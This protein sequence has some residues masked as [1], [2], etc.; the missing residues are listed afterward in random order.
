MQDLRPE[1]PSLS[2]RSIK[3]SAVPLIKDKNFQV[4][5]LFIYNE[6]DFSEGE[7]FEEMVNYNCI[8]KDFSKEG[9]KE[10]ML[11][12]VYFKG[13]LAIKNYEEIGG[14]SVN[15]RKLPLF[16]IKACNDFGQ[17]V[18]CAGWSEKHKSLLR[19]AENVWISCLA[20]R[21]EIKYKKYEAV[22]LNDC[23][24]ENL[25]ERKIESSNVIDLTLFDG[26]VLSLLTH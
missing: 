9:L 2:G 15:G 24:V 10:T 25:L 4:P 21:Y 12:T 14:L 22:L 23:I 3:F 19:N 11:G 26:D 1:A 6:S 20:I 17:H 16:K 5:A 18:D 7:N 13:R 8:I